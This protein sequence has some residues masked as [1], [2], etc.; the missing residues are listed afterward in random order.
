[1]SLLPSVGDPSDIAQPIPMEIDGDSDYAEQESP[2]I[3]N[4][5]QILFERVPSDPKVKKLT[6]VCPQS[7]DKLQI[8]DPGAF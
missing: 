7:L 1:M 5:N 8:T 4:A 3:F 6:V 2:S